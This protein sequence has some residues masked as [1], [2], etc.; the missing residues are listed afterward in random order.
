MNRL[1]FVSI[2]L[3]FAVLLSARVSLRAA[4]MP[5]VFAIDASLPADALKTADAAIMSIAM[6]VSSDSEIQSH[7]I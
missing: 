6:Q 3:M 4:D 1:R 7:R 2:L 5:V